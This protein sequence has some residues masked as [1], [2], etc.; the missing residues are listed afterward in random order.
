[1]ICSY[2]S[3]WDLHQQYGIL[4]LFF[5]SQSHVCD[6]TRRCVSPF[7]YQ[8]QN[9][10]SFLYCLC[11]WCLKHYWS[12]QF[13]GGMSYIT[14]AI[15]QVTLE[16]LQLSGRVS[17]VWGSNAHGA[18]EFLFAHTHD[19]TKKVSFSLLWFSDLCFFRCSSKDNLLTLDLSN[20][21]DKANSMTTSLD[22]LSSDSH[23]TN[24]ELSTP[25]RNIIHHSIRYEQIFWHW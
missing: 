14:I 19:K 1:M 12:Q 9:L 16:S 3:C 20:L 22:T 24:G 13:A 8:A 2:M 25:G 17:E 18:S 11:T 21:P 4:I 5:G 7:H 15:N 23:E 6:K 10:P